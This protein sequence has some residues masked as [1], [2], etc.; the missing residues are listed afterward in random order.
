MTFTLTSVNDDVTVTLG[1][2]PPFSCA[3]G[4]YAERGKRM[5]AIR[6]QTCPVEPLS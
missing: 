3:Y 5:L 4:M 1:P 6:L 2:R